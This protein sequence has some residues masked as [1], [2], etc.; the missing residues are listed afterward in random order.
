M[1][2]NAYSL[3]VGSSSRFVG[4]GHCSEIMQD[5][6]GNDWM[7]FHGWDVNNS[8]NG[9]VLLLNKVSWDRS[10][11]PYVIASSPTVTGDAPVFGTSGQNDVYEGSVQLLSDSNGLTILS[12]QPVFAKVYTIAGQLVRLIRVTEPAQ[13][14]LATGIYIVHINTTGYTMVKKIFIT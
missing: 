1:M 10:G 6:A 13:I 14:R 8:N 4:N 11:W 12:S 7:F 3:V 2:N 9:R 5:D